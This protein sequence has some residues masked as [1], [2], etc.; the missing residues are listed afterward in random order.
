MQKSVNLK[1]AFT[2]VGTLAA[3]TWLFLL[4][5][6]DSSSLS[7]W[8][9]LKMIPEAAG[10]VSTVALLFAKYGWRLKIFSGWLVLV[11]DLNGTW[12]G[13]LKSEWINP[14]TS[15]KPDPI[16]AYLVIRQSL[17]RISCVLH[18]KES[19]SVSK[20]S[21]ILVDEDHQL[22]SLEFSYS[23]SPRVSVQHRSNA[24]D[25][26]TVLDILST[27]DRKLVGKYWTDRL[28]KGE[29]ELNFESKSY[30][31]SFQG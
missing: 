29:L 16:D 3:A 1:I 11:P 9:A 10:Y 8:N 14:E 13:Q 30:R 22:K 25:G 28:S 4:S 27:P 18:T 2:I 23:N 12:K 15:A 7:D 31:Q 26:A 17:N 24:H 19:R 21:A 20:A 6:R 5:L